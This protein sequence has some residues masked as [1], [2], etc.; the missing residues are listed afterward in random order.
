MILTEIDV[1][2]LQE[3]LAKVDLSY[4]HKHTSDF[5]SL[6]LLRREHTRLIMKPEKNHKRPHFHIKYKREHS[7]SYSII[8][9]AYMTG[10]LPK[11]YEKPIL[12][13]AE[14]RI[15]SLI[16]T[17]TALESGKDVRELIIE[18]EAA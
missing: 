4:S 15:N 3:V 11:K 8:P 9:L 17:W 13:W 2:E 10:D 5:T 16:A 18:V 12:E 7:S 14:Q 1:K 6:V